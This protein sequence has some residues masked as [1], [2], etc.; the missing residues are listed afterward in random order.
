MFETPIFDFAFNMAFYFSSSV[1]NMCFGKFGNKFS[2][3]VGL[4]I[5]NL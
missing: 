5:R 3:P 4:F 1:A 2:N